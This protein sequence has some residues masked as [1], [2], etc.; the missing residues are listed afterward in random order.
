MKIHVISL[1]YGVPLMIKKSLEEYLLKSTLKDFKH[2]ILNNQYPLNSEEENMELDEYIEDNG[3]ILIENYRN[4]GIQGGVNRLFEAAKP[5]DDDILIF[6]GTDSFPDNVGFDEALVKIHEDSSVFMANINNPLY[7]FMNDKTKNR[8]FFKDE[9]INNLNVWTSERPPELTSVA[10]ARWK[11][12]KLLGSN[13]LGDSFCG[14]MTCQ[15]VVKDYVSQNNL[16]YAVLVD[17]YDNPVIKKKYTCKCYFDYV[18]ENYKGGKNI[19]F[20]DYLK[21][22]K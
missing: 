21:E 12:I 9:I 2:Y 18:S 6:Y 15:D 20:E 5:E 19:R 14:E 11:H 16:K 1:V 8:Y 10:S 7:S 22:E 4:L 3:Y 17:Y 13:F